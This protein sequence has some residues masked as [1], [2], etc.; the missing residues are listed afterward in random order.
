MI[1]FARFIAVGLFNTAIGY[2]F[3]LAFLLLGFGDY[4]AN[5]LGF[6]FG[7]PVSF[8]MH[9]RLTFRVGISPHVGEAS[10]Y[11]AAVL[12]AY[13]GNLGVVT[14]GRQL[15]YV[16]NPLVQALAIATYAGVFFVLCKLFVFADTAK[17]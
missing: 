16:E 14:A 15:G 5:L 1:T 4:S 10:R 17:D 2:G 3:I 11:A 9:R 12:V 13:L 8:L 6:V 7:L